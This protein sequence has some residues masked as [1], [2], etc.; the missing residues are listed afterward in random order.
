MKI[1]LEKVGSGLFPCDAIGEQWMESASK[2]KYEIKKV[3]ERSYK[4]LSMYFVMLKIAFDN[5]ERFATQDEMEDALLLE[6]GHT[7][8]REK[9]NGEKYLVPRSVA[10]QKSKHEEFTQLVDR[11]RGKIIDVW[12]YDPLETRGKR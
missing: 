6:V 1:F 4:Q 10:Y 3:S 2:G 11:M 5:Q 8:L 12:D 7:E 9:M